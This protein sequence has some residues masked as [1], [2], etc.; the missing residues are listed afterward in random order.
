MS[1]SELL[2]SIMLD[3]NYS[4]AQISRMLGITRQ[5]VN[6][7]YNG[8]NK[9]SVKSKALLREKFP[10]F[11]ENPILPDKLT[12][13]TLRKYR[14]DSQLTQ[15]EF[16]FMLGMSQSQLAQLE[17]DKAIISDKIKDNF[18]KVFSKDNNS[19]TVYYCPETTIPHNFSVPENPETI[20]IDKRLLSVDKGLSVNYSHTYIVSISGETMSPDYMSSDKVLLDTSQKSFNDGYT[21]FIYVNKIPYIRYVNVLP[22]KIKCVPFNNK[23]DTFYLEKTSEYEVVGVILPRIRL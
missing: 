4:Q 14:L 6:L 9:F 23:Q 10:K 13:D 15:E 1:D 3:T 7:V 2:K 8:K 21:Y 19:V 12:A 5:Y 20:T 11:F 17:N 16:A 22:D 18:F